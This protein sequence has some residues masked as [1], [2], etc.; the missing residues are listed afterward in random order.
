[1]AYE[2]EIGIWVDHLPTMVIDVNDSR[3]NT[4]EQIW[5]FLEGTANV[6]FSILADEPRRYAFVTHQ[7]TQPHCHH[8]V[9]AP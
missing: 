3:L 2:A 4:I 7:F 8:R 9:A 1:M 6:D 5:Q